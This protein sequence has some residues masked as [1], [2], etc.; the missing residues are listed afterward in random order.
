MTRFHE[1]GSRAALAETLAN[2]VAA[3][4]RAAVE[5]R[6]RASL[7]VSGGS[8][9]KLFFETLSKLPLAW[10]KVAVT[11]V[12]ERFVP[13]ENERSNHKLVTTHLLQNAAAA[14]AFLPLYHAGM[15]AAEAAMTASRETCGID[16]PFDVAIIGLGTDGHTA[17]FFPGGDNLDEALDAAAARGVM[18]MEAQGAGET[19]LTFTFS[20][21]RDAR[22]LALHIEGDEKKAVLHKA[23]MAGPEREMP[24]RAF[25]NRS[26]S[27]LEIYW[28]P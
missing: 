27:P 25:L 12:D 4:L 5:Q 8:T 28:A 22:F 20:A 24:I 19:R 23:E 13:P 16:E 11:L 1:F 2:A 17:S 3:A 26:L 6:G 10:D 9:P 7:A 21:L 18:T 14:A 15:S